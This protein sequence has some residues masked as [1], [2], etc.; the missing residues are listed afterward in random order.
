MDRSFLT[1]ESVSYRYPG[2]PEPVLRG[3]S[4]SIGPGWTAVAGANGCGKT[5]L[6][7]LACG[8]MQPDQGKVQASGR[9]LYC[10]QRTDRPPGGFEDFVRAWSHPAIMDMLGVEWDWPGRWETLSHG[11]RKRA[12]LAMALAASPDILAVD[13]P[14]NHLDSSARALVRD[15]LLE[16]RGTGLLV[17]HDRDLIDSLASRCGLLDAGGMTLR[18]GGYSVARREDGREQSSLRDGREKAREKYFRIKRDARRKQ[19]AARTLQARSCGRKVTY[20]DICL[21]GID[22]P[23]RIDGSVQKAGQ[24][25]R[26]ALARMER[27]RDEMESIRF[28]KEYERGISMP[29]Q[30][31]G[32]NL[33]VDLPGGILR[34]GDLRLEHPRLCLMPDHRVALTGPNGSGKSTLVR[35]LVEGADLPEGRLLYIPQELTGDESAEFLDRARSL[36]PEELGGVMSCVRRLGTDPGPLL[37]SRLPSPG[38][39]RKLMLCLGLLKRPWLVI[40]DEPTNHLDLPGIECLEEA[41]CGLESALLLVSHDRRFLERTTTEEWRVAPDDGR[42]SLSIFRTGRRGT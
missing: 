19:L 21:S 3:L 42:M 28:R 18:K 30:R 10:M 20:R 12:Q 4:F 8:L 39:T 6:L 2:S 1:F 16:Y 15:A 27:A 38:E 29:G 37:D 36:G 25:S 35:R 13:E 9:A 5:T 33:L 34:L 11:E 23:S 17:S 31:S 40:M 32:R 14:V 41:L 26:T 7:R 22:G 24:L